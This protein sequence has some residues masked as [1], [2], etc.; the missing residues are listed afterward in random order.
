MFDAVADDADLCAFAERARD[1][2]H[3]FRFIVSPEDATEMADLRAFTRDL[4]RQ[5]EHTS[6]PSW[7]GSPSITGTPTT[8]TSI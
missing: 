4:L 6:G 7:I 5:M 1:D 8:R 2:R 3:Q